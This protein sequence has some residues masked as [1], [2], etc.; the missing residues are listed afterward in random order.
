MTAR[1]QSGF[2]FAI[3]LLITVAERADARGTAFAGC[4]QPK[5]CSLIAAT[6]AYTASQSIL[7]ATTSLHAAIYGSVAEPLE[8]N[9]LPGMTS[10]GELP[11]T[12]PIGSDTPGFGRRF[13][14]T[15]FYVNGVNLAD[16]LEGANLQA[17]GAWGIP[18]YPDAFSY[19]FNRRWRFKA[20]P[21]DDGGP[22]LDA[23]AAGAESNSEDLLRHLT[24]PDFSVNLGLV[25]MF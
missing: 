6:V 1:R 16:Q 18:E 15:E 5:N 17:F 4:T 22:A 7:A 24:D 13:G 10:G 9:E 3:L 2:L 19:S 12:L 21:M 25:R 11:N 23:M 20:N 8:A 14:V